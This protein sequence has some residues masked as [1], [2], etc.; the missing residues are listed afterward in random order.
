M[1]YHAKPFIS[2]GQFASREAV[3][4]CHWLDKVA[5]DI[6]FFKVTLKRFTKCIHILV[7]ILIN[8]CSEYSIHHTV[9]ITQYTLSS[10]VLIN[11]IY[12]R[13]KTVRDMLHYPRCYTFHNTY[14][15]LKH[16]S[17]PE[18]R[19][20]YW[21]ET[22]TVPWNDLFGKVTI[23]DVRK[24]GHLNIKTTLRHAF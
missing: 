12:F 3:L 4:G 24:A 11:K 20:A 15:T 17:H 9:N 14:G 23:L 8:G 2:I 13:L 1:C 22:I 5:I 18:R 21:E 7:F 6:L 16:I 19:K 10:M